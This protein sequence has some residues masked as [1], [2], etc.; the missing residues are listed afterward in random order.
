MIH[1]IWYNEEDI[2]K[3]VLINSFL[4]CCISQNLDGAQDD[5]FRWPV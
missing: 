2:K 4:V 5:L 1:K 3:T